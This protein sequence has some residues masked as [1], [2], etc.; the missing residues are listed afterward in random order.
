MKSETTEAARRWTLL[1]IPIILSIGYTALVGQAAI[2]F[3][4]VTLALHLTQV[5]LI[6]ARGTWGNES[7]K[8]PPMNGS[9]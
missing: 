1:R 6:V 7:Q 2:G 9:Y 5:L 8:K 4:D 3:L